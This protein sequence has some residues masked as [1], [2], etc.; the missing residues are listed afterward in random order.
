M[1][2]LPVVRN[3]RTRNVPQQAKC[4]TRLL[5]CIS[6]KKG[7]VAPPVA[8]GVIACSSIPAKFLLDASIQNM[9]TFPGKKLLKLS[10]SG[11]YSDH[12]FQPSVLARK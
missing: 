4:T 3:G 8:W 7:L 11:A 6:V 12:T 1:T 10:Y 2:S 9:T 5:Y